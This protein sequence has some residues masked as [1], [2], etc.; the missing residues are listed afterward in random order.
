MKFKTDHLI[1]A[2]FKKYREFE[3][4]TQLDIGD[5]LYETK[6]SIS[7]KEKGLSYWNLNS[8]I[9]LSELL[10]F[11]I[12]IEEGE[13]ELMKDGFDNNK[14]EE[15]RINNMEV[16]KVKDFGR[17]S[18]IEVYSN[19]EDSKYGNISISMEEVLE[20]GR[21]VLN[22]NSSSSII[23]G[24]CLY[25]NE[26]GYTPNS[27]RD[28]HNTIDDAE[29]EYYNFFE[30]EE[31]FDIKQIRKEIIEYFNNKGEDSALSHIES[32]KDRYWGKSLSD[33]KLDLYV[34]HDIS[35]EAEWIE[36][37]LNLELTDYEWKYCKSRFNKEVLDLFRNG[38]N[39]LL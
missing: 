32:N 29:K 21:E 8:I 23:I 12:I 14:L 19:T 5:Y 3:G 25:D 31:E 37:T 2:I 39:H 28:W 24:Y 22:R 1:G 33:I 16:K 18:I 17:F 15:G 13:L 38:F 27:A 34:N 7:K 36:E 9:K 10:K 35:C 26:I 4:Y 6:Q 30:V 11:K 20:D